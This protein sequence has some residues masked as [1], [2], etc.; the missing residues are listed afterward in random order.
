MI[1]FWEGWET[2]TDERVMKGAIAALDSSWTG[3][4][5]KSSDGGNE[6][7]AMT[8]GGIS[9]SSSAAGKDD[10]KFNAMPVMTPVV[11]V[12]NGLKARQAN[13]IGAVGRKRKR[14]VGDSRLLGS[15]HSQT[16]KTNTHRGTQKKKDVEVIDLVDSD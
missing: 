8:Q 5:V 10:A 3:K 13:A 6:I 11:P 4:E 1:W 9:N 7:A 12:E 15:Y 2:A 14:A 16:C